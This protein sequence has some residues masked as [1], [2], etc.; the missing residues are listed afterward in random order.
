MLCPAFHNCLAPSGGA[1]LFK[2]AHRDSPIESM[3]NKLG[4][5]KIQI[6]TTPSELGHHAGGKHSA[7][8]MVARAVRGGHF[9]IQ[10]SGERSRL[11]WTTESVDGAN[12]R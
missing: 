12:F 4:R 8:D 5:P 1:E 7:A 3:H 9:F 11:T 6:K 10:W 2:I